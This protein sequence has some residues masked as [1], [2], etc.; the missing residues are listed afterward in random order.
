[1]HARAGTHTHARSDDDDDDD[2]DSYRVID[3]SDYWFVQHE[4][5]FDF[6]FA[7]LIFD[8]LHGIWRLMQWDKAMA[9]ALMLLIK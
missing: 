6:W 1:M 4:L 7:H 8:R 5:G 2:G 3:L 9:S